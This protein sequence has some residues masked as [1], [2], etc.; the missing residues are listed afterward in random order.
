MGGPVPTLL[1]CAA[2]AASAACKAQIGPD[3]GGGPDSSTPGLDARSVDAAIDAVQLGSW[4]RPQPV[5]GASTGAIEDDG[6]LSST[7]NELVFAVVD[8]AANNAKDLWYMSRT[9]PAAPWSAPTKLPFNSTASDETPRFSPDDLTL[10]FASGRAGGLGGLDIYRVTRTAVGGAW[11]T[12]QLVPGVN[13]T[14][15]EKWF[16][17][18]ATGNTYLTIYN[19]DIAEGTLGSPPT[20]VAAL[21]SASTETGTFLSPDC[22]TVYFASNRNG[23]NQLFVSTRTAVGAPWA[24]PSLVT[25][26]QGLGGAQED[27]W[28][29]SDL[30]TFALVSDIGG[31]KDVYISTR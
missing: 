3:P 23:A 21:S 6:S 25:D 5:A 15:T 18:C 4:G 10:Y 14:L 24:V 29:S 7:T 12:P 31:T 11:G 30:R 16:V 13:T 22:L 17:P 9:S 8:P 27:P 20:V 26:F 28:L 2:F 1:V 19:N